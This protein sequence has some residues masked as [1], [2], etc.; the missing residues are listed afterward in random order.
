MKE[1]FSA[2]VKAQKEFGP[3]LKSSTNPHFRTKYAALDAC[4]EAVIDALNNN[5]IMLM[6]QTHPCDDG[7]I[8]ETTFIHESGQLFSAGK[9]HIPAGKHDPQG[10]GG[11]LTYARR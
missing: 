3:A 7:V 2:L 8:V 5:G 6:Q 4:I 9:L 1:I 10:F 11:A